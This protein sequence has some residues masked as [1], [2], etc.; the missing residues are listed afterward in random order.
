MP[1]VTSDALVNPY[2]CGRSLSSG[3]LIVPLP[4]C[5]LPEYVV[6]CFIPKQE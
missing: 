3:F 4:V 1:V 5:S 6:G 2:A